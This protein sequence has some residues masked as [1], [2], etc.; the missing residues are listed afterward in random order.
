MFLPFVWDTVVIEMDSSDKSHQEGEFEVS[1]K[2]Y[3]VDIWKAR[4]PKKQIV[5]ETGMTSFFQKK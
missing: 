2:V 1:E 5:S 4:I 3:D